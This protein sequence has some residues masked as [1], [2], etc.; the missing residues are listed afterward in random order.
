M[1]QVIYFTTSFDV[2]LVTPVFGVGTIWLRTQVMVFSFSM[3]LFGG[4]IAVSIRT[5]F[6]VYVAFP[7]EEM[8][9]LDLKTT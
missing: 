8:Q 5:L 2:D 3:I 9:S 6:G 1:T 7:L 4:F